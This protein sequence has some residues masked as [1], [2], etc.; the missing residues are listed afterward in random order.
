MSYNKGPDQPV[1]SRIYS[2]VPI[3]SVVENEGPSLKT[4]MRGPIQDFVI[5]YANN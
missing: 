1:H 5:R 4:R 3:E 2:T